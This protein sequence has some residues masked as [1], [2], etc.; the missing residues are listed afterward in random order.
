MTLRPAPGALLLTLS[1]ACAA[2]PPA[3]AQT[4]AVNLSPSQFPG[5]LEGPV[6]IGPMTLVN[7]TQERYRVR[8]FGVLLGQRRDGGI[9]VRDDRRSRARARRVLETQGGSFR[10]DPGNAQSV[11]ARVRRVP[12]SGSFYGGVLFQAT[13]R[14]PRGTA[15]PQIRNVLQLTASVLLDPT[16]RRRRVRLAAGTIRARSVRKRLRLLV[17]V[18]NRGNGYERLSGRVAVRNG[19]GRVVARPRVKRLRVL[20][21]ATV[22]LPAVVAARLPAGRYR[23]SGTIRAAGRRVRAAGSMRLFGVNQ[24]A[25]RTARITNMRAPTAYKG[26]ELELKGEFRNTGN[27]DYSPRAQVQVRQ[28]RNGTPG[29][30]AVTREMDAERAAPGQKG[31]LETKLELPGDAASYQLTV[32]LLGAGE[33]GAQRDVSVTP[34]DKPPLLTR[35][36]DW[37]TGNALVIVALLLA[38]MAAGAVIGT[39]YVRRLKAEANRG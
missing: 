36:K 8:V 20:P 11:N 18:T 37:V 3:A 24:V 12:R 5:V 30:V 28:V 38:L 17:A 34:T 1:L 6:R 15:R 9:V 13:P 21:G 10:F 31:S 7:G 26:E 25:T 29:R 23:L 39:R 2:A 33:A 35:A 32:R 19:A 27:V 14:R 22:D 16:A 4:A